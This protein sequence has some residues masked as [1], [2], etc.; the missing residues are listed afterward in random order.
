[1][2]WEN[3]HSSHRTVWTT[4]C[5]SHRERSTPIVSVPQNKW[6]DSCHPQWSVIC[7][8]IKTCCLSCSGGICLCAVF[9]GGINSVRSNEAVRMA[10]NVHP[11]MRDWVYRIVPQNMFKGITSTTASPCRWME[12]WRCTSYGRRRRKKRRR[13]RK[14]RNQQQNMLDL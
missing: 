12:L 13:R 6:R 10:E 9:A 8:E 14:R 5:L 1:M 11:E 2:P 3:V 4:L 7:L